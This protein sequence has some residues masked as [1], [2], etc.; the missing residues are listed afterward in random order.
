LQV[1]T[2][3]DV[4]ITNANAS[5]YSFIAILRDDGSGT[6]DP[7]A[8]VAANYYAVRF[9]AAANEKFFVVVDSLAT[10]LTVDTRI[11]C[12][13]ATAETSC[14]D[15]FDNDGDY[16]TDCADP[17]CDTSAACSP[18]R[19]NSSTQIT[20]G[21]KLV[22]SSTGAG[23][24]DVIDQYA[25]PSAT[26]SGPERAFTFQ[27]ETSGPVVFTV[28][29]FTGYPMLYVLEDDGS[30]NPNRCI[31]FNSVR[32]NAVA[33]RTYHLVAD[34]AGNS[35]YSFRVSV[36]C[37]APTAEASSGDFVD[38]GGDFKVD[39]NDPD[40]T[41]A[42][43]CGSGACVARCRR[44][45]RLQHPIPSGQYRGATESHVGIDVALFLCARRFSE[46]SRARV[47]HLPRAGARRP[48]CAPLECEQP[49]WLGGYHRGTQRDVWPGCMYRRRLRSGG[50]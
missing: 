13:A 42:S 43:S 49:Q 20:C 10:N 31:A 14:G 44:Y 16:K 8:C 12:G 11:E 34:G 36:I 6:I 30:C 39:C 7:G 23:S 28:S 26:P 4:V 45:S 21:Q 18:G 1:P 37:D 38:D 35:S 9:T 2:A 32:W 25:C 29:D 19:C 33:G 24:T 46:R 15:T 40:C 22:A 47:Q 5:D 17:D 48:D 50:F 41:N 27:A 3:G